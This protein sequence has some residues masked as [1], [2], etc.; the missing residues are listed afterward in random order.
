MSNKRSAKKEMTVEDFAKWLLDTF[1]KEAP[2]MVA[3]GAGT[4][5]P[6][7]KERA[8]RM[9]SKRNVRDVSDMFFVLESDTAFKGHA[10]EDEPLVEAVLVW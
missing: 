9:V 10:K 6:V 3:D 5:V 2:V 8:E 4:F 1:P 7:T